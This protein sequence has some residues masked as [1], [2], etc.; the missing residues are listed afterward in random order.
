[1]YSSLITRSST[2]SSK[3]AKKLKTNEVSKHKWKRRK[4]FQSYRHSSILK[5]RF[6]SISPRRRYRPPSLPSRTRNHSRA[7]HSVRRWGDGVELGSTLRY[8]LGPR[9]RRGGPSTGLWDRERRRHSREKRADRQGARGGTKQ[10]PP[11]PPPRHSGSS[12]PRRQASAP[13]EQARR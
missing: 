3:A 13:L 7:S 1:M 12:T 4:H 6:A 2:A 10:P 9:S 8:A 11:P 5:W